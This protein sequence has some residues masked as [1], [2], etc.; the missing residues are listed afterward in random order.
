MAAFQLTVRSGESGTIIVFARSGGYTEKRG[1]YWAAG[2]LHSHEPGHFYRFDQ[3]DIR[4]VVSSG[5]FTCKLAL[6]LAEVPADT[7]VW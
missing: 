5:R 3:I 7:N 2:T 4:K 6:I 1:C